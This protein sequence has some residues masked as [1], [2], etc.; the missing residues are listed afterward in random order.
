MAKQKEAVEEVN[1]DL[2]PESQLAGFLKANKTDHYNFEE[3]SFYKISSGSLA[4]DIEMGGG[5][6]PGF[7]RFCGLSE[8]GKSSEALEVVK[9]FLATVPNSRAVLIKAE[10]RLSQEMQA[11]SGVE[12]TTKAE[13]WGNGTCFVYESNI[14]ESVVDLM[15]N[16]IVNNP[17]K[18]KYIF[19]I[20]SADALQLR[21]DAE[22]DISEA[23]KVAGGA[24]ISSVMMKKMA[25]AMSK[26]GH[27]VIMISQLR[28]EVKI[29]PYAKSM[30]RV[31]GA[32][33]GFALQHYPNWVLEFEQRYNGDLILEKA[34]EKPDRI[35]NK[36][37]GHW[38]KIVIRKSVNEKT[39]LPLSYPVKYGRTGG[40]SIWLEYE[41]AD[42]LSQFKFI[43]I[44]GSWITF[45]EPAIKKAKEV[46]IELVEKIQG[47]DKL[48]EYLESNPKINEYFFS[49]FK[50]ALAN[51]T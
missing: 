29:D 35:K 44:K 36:I 47:M 5:F 32:S 1:E 37:L 41:I 48:R 15:R 45:T 12:F 49:I 2:S 19:V 34:K 9:N 30:P 16:L 42:M 43:D 7:H 31:G 3:D 11:R 14:H 24:V 33:G 10:G 51:E 18:I 50:N 46:G 21:A 28:S 13:D 4:L 40:K 8:G 26:R 38:C 22:K 6:N 39:N 25:I 23:V 20:D 17:T 27:M